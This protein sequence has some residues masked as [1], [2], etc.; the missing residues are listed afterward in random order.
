MEIFWNECDTKGHKVK[1]FCSDCGTMF[2]CEAVLTQVRKRGIE[3]RK[4]KVFCSDCGTMFR[5]EAVLTQV[6]KRGIEFRPSCLYTSVAE[7][8]RHVI[9]LARSMLSVRKLLKTV[10]PHASD[11]AVYLISRTGKSCVAGK[12]PF[13]LWTGVAFHSF[14]IL[15]MLC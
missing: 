1:V 7:Q 12:A 4:V 8:A 6:R 3:F 15:R 10:W 11:T 9:E 2:R 5:C 14:D 13:E